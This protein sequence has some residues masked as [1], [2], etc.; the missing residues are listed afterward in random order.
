MLGSLPIIAPTLLGLFLLGGAA[1]RSGLIHRVPEW[2]PRLR[3]W[4]V[5]AIFAG[6]VGSLGL[7]HAGLRGSV[8]DPSLGSLPGWF[9]QTIAAPLQGLGYAAALLL[10]H[11]TPTGRRWLAPFRPVGRIALTNYLTHSVVFIGLNAGWGLGRYGTLGPARVTVIAI[12]LFA[13]QMLA[14][15]LWLQRFRFGPIEALWRMMTYGRL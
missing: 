8:A 12:G 1:S 3:P 11:E 14:S 2:A 10:A 5:P 7:V 4:I 15:R 6:A 13:L 9:G